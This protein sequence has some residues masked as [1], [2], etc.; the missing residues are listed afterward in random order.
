MYYCTLKHYY[1][2]APLSVL[3]YNGLKYLLPNYAQF[4]PVYRNEF[5]LSRI[6][7]MFSLL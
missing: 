1:C 7:G 6:L 2:M 3:L 4:A 5:T